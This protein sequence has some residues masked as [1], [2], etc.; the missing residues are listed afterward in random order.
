M[1]GG[2]EVLGK[3]FKKDNNKQLKDGLKVLR[4]NY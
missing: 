4:K 1:L 3:L 2:R